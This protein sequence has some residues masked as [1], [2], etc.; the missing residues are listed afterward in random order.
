MYIY[1]KDVPLHKKCSVNET[2][3]FTPYNYHILPSLQFS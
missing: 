1:I 3:T 2:P